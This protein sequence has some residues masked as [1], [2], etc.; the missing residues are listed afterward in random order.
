M[1]AL[2]SGIPP[3]DVSVAQSDSV[4]PS[5]RQLAAMA[6]RGARGTRP[7]SGL[8]IIICKYGIY[9]PGPFEL[10]VP[11]IRVLAK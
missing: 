1:G 3:P 11:C 6:G 9:W 5:D 8:F 2:Y 10:R 7:T 4:A